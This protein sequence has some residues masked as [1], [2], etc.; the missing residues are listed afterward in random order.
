AILSL[1]AQA[2]REG[3]NKSQYDEPGSSSV[4]IRDHVCL[5]STKTGITKARS[6]TKITKAFLSKMI[7]RA[8]R[9]S[10]CLRD[11]SLMPHATP[12][13]TVRDE[14]SRIICFRSRGLAYDSS[15]LLVPLL[16]FVLT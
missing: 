12:L 7:V 1:C 4:L 9:G 3:N 10:S 11:E 5:R 2:E 6:N 14:G 15:M 16:T 8:L 13:R